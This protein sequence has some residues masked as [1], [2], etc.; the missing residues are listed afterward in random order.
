MSSTVLSIIIIAYLLLLFL[1]AFIAEKKGASKW[2][3]NA[4]T[5]TLSLAVYCTAWTYFGSVGV[6]AQSGLDFLPIYLGPVIASPLW[7][8]VLQ[9]IIRI[10]RQHKISSL[11]DFISIRYGNSRM[12]GA[13]VTL[14][15][16]MAIV[17]YI[18]LQLKAVS[19]SFHILTNRSLSTNP[20]LLQDTTL[21]IAI[22]LGLFASFYGTRKTDASE[23]HPGIVASTAFESLLKL[24]FFLGI[25]V[26][27]T[28]FLFDGTTDIY[29]RIQQQTSLGSSVSLTGLEQG[30]NWL[31]IMIVS[32]LAIFLLPRQFQLAVVEN[33]NI[34]HVKKAL[35]LFPLYLLIFNF[36]VLYIAWGGNL[37]FGDN[38]QAEYYSLLLPM[39]NNQPLLSLMVFLGGFSAVVS[40]VVV[41]TLALSTMLS[42]NLFIPYGFLSRFSKRES[43]YNSSTIKNIRRVSIFGIILLAYLFYS[44]F[45]VNRSLFSI[46]L[47][48]FVLIA[49]LAPS[50]FIGLFWKRG[51]SKAAM[52]GIAV[53]ILINVYTLIIPFTLN[54]Y[55]IEARF[56][57][58]GLFGQQ[59]LVPTALFGIDF[60]SAPAHAFMWSMFGNG[61][62]FLFVSVS[63]KGN[64]RERNYAEMFI[65]V[66]N[67]D[68]LQDN[69]LVWK[70]EALVADIKEVLER[71]LGKPRTE[72]ALN[73][74]FKKYDISPQ[75]KKADARLINFSKNL[76][77][78]SIGSASAKILISKVVREEKISLVEVLEI[79]EE[80]KKSI[81]DN[82]SLQAQSK[83]L[84]RLTDELKNV[85]KELLFKDHQKDEFLDTVAHELK[86]P[87][88]GIRASTEL[89]LDDEGDMPLELQ[90]QFLSNVLK[91]SERL[92]RLINNL[93]DFEKLASDRL[94]LNMREHVFY[95]TANRV[96][97]SIQNIAKKKNVKLHLANQEKDQIIYD[98]DRITQVLTNL[99][100]NAL[101]FCPEENGE[102]AVSFKLNDQVLECHVKDNGKG[103]PEEDIPYIFDRFYQS[104][105]QTTIKPIGSGLGLS[106]CKRIVE[107]HGGDIWAVPHLRTGAEVVFTIPNH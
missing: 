39:Q 72:R 106:I 9:K 98:D 87:I 19:E 26:Y 14:V 36:F 107:K 13:V 32:F 27:V 37:S 18:A 6:A 40:M 42:N 86:T 20:A 78:G 63:S 74:F 56:I 103:I 15:S 54:A 71:F 58:E 41:S 79:L 70:G 34:K 28:F 67:Y 8:V 62:V 83:Q 24:V 68:S 31:M 65:D 43:E 4:Y 1:V 59:V 11:A 25:G 76:L 82:K 55:G 64:Y 93:L 3:N 84:T 80:S 73:L 77:T 104:G 10:S 52:L 49:Q 21:Y 45:A 33:T 38:S 5:Y 12:L 100:S 89:L 22:I 44:G 48:S 23:K 53:G 101:K 102:V 61:I 16:T 95:E 81:S 97:H 60:L 105:N 66:S 2:V 35:W 51:S 75:A 46:G 88:T 85:N 92:S 7:I 99:I 50:F 30:F 91:D 17:P 29:D 96:I 94:K 69:A 57:S 47:V 90:K